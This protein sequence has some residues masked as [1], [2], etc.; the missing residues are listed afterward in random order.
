MVESRCASLKEGGD[1]HHAAFLGY[2]AEEVGGRTGYGFGEVEVVH[3]LHLAEVERVVQFLQHN[4]LRTLSGELLY[5]LGEAVH[6]VCCVGN[7]ML[8]QVS[9]FQFVHKFTFGKC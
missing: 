9:Y 5:A 8:L 7:I 2:R 6:V 1:N 4:E 3:I